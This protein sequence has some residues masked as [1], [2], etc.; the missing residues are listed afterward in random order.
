MMPI[1]GSLRLVCEYADI[2]SIHS[3]MFVSLSSVMGLVKFVHEEMKA[4]RLYT[5][6]PRLLSFIEELSNWY[7]RLNRDRV[8]GLLGIYTIIFICNNFLAF[9]LLT[10]EEETLIG[11]N[12]LFEVLVIM[13]LIMSPFTPFFTEYLYQ[14]LRKYSSA[15]Q[16]TD[17]SIPLDVFGKANSVHYLMLPVPDESRLNATGLTNYI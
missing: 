1:S 5:V 7:V 8:K 12:V 2:Q 6:V 3:L 15:Y 10:G 16:S 14:H 17:E 4:Y 13:T 9:V 11:L